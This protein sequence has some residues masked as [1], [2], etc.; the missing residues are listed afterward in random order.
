MDSTFWHDRWA[1][2]QIGFH[3]PEVNPYLQRHWPGLGLASG[4][5]VL[6][7]LCGKSLDLLWLVQQGY[8]VLGVELS[9][10]AVEEFFQEQHLTAQVSQRGD[11][12]VYQ[13]D[14]IELWCGDFFQLSGADVAGCTAL[15]DRA[16]LIALPPPM[17]ERYV[18]HL[19][20]IAPQV[21][22]GL[23]IS[24][25]YEQ[26]LKAG[27]PFAVSDDEVRGLLGV[28]WRLSVLE[29]RDILAESPK[30]AQEGV[31]RLEERVYQLTGR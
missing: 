26:A 21:Q 5:R 15:Y 10:K 18:A 1:R 7:P 14:A 17:R 19:Q 30:F 29:Q 16:A 4:A 25:D 9:Q 23:L 11:F 28:H 2:N 12:K 20:A 24:L 22:D 8:R 6:V 13:A 27:P 3:L 31:A